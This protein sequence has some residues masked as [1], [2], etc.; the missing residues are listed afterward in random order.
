MLLSIHHCK[1][2]VNNCVITN[3]VIRIENTHQNMGGKRMKFQLPMLQIQY[4]YQMAEG[5]NIQKQDAKKTTAHV[6]RV[7]PL[8][9]GS[10]DLNETSRKLF[11]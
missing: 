6:Y 7:L 4:Q 10:P 1:L 11:M 5:E 3:N 8:W 2:G 9:G